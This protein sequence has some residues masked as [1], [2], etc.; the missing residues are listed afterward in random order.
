[1]LLSLLIALPL[2]AQDRTAPL[3]ERAL[4]DPAGAMRQADGTY[5]VWVY[6]TDKG[7]GANELG[8]ALDAVE[9]SLPERTLRRRAKMT[10]PGQRLVDG[11]DLPVAPAYIAAVENE[12]AGARR[13]SRWLNAASFDATR[14]QINA[15]ATLPFVTRIDLV[16]R[17]RR[18]TPPLTEDEQEL[19]REALEKSRLEAED[20]WSLNYGP[21]LDGLEQINV[22]PV[23]EMGITGDGV[24][25]GML[26]S[27]FKTT[28]TALSDIPVI[29][30][31]DFVNDDEIVENEPGDPSNQHNHGTK[32]LSTIMGFED[33]ELVAPAF[34]ATAILAKTEDVSQEIPIEEDNWVAGL[35]WVESLGADIVSSSLGYYDWYEFADMDGNTAVTTIAAD[36]AVGRGLCV[37][38]SAGNERGWGFG[39]H[40][41]RRRRQRDHR[42]RRH[43]G[44]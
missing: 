15:I 33:G 1:M 40:R 44:R 36:L 42:G 22:P 19:S 24:V 12:G 34:G 20:R 8:A 21:S 4:A 3:L 2:A 9:A 43:P 35:E 18:P 25:I 28:H 26:D 16:A 6:F 13:Q 11:R 39:H 5:A 31:Y 29:A 10:E 30:R 23:H 7:L 37:V 14:D 17:F 38:N 41:A 27:G 32:T